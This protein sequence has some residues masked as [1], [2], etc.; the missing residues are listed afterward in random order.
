VAGGASM[1]G[2]DG[3]TAG[4]GGGLSENVGWEF[5][6]DKMGR[7]FVTKRSGAGKG[8]SDPNYVQ[9]IAGSPGVLRQ[10]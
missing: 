10:P 1:D 3:Q 7:E 4:L 5:H 6:G 8:D 2:V 9:M